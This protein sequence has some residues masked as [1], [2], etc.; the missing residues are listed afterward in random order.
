MYTA[1]TW[2]KF[3]IISTSLPHQYDDEA[4]DY[5]LELIAIV[6]ACKWMQQQWPMVMPMVKPHLPQTQPT[7][8]QQ[9]P[10][11]DLHNATQYLKDSI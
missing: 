1:P 6:A 11:T 4:F 7:L 5:Q 8:N 2:G 9:S 10:D 3:T